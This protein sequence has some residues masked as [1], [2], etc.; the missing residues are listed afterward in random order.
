[1]FVR[2][3]MALGLVW[4]T[5]PANAETTSVAVME[6]ASKGGVTQKQ[7]DALG[8]MLANEIRDL[9][10]FRVIGKSDIRAMLQFE[11]QKTLMGCSDVAC[12]AEIGGA[13]GVK[14]VVIGNIGMFGN[15]YLLNLKLMDSEKVQVGS[16]IS[17]KVA[18]GEAALLDS[19]ARA[20]GDLFGKVM[21]PKRT[22]TTRTAPRRPAPQTKKPSAI[23]TAQVRPNPTNPAVQTTSTL[24]AQAQ[25]SGPFAYNTWG[26]VSMWTGVGVT[27]LGILSFLVSE[28]AKSDWMKTGDKDLV[29]KHEMWSSLAYTGLL[30]GAGL[31]A[32]GTTLWLLEPDEPESSVP[33]HT[34]SWSAGMIT[35]GST[36]FL[37]IGG[38]W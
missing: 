34:A 3:F 38:R 24:E 2:I 25:A 30:L 12:M 23:T 36:C 4:G 5:L 13:L 14:W 35:D 10:D 18:G 8:D 15:I 17:R 9:G 29:N 27:S 22:A 11:E 31:I 19:L 26:H 7:M 6:F 37:H 1:M 33:A 21:K 32:T 16:S 28:G 20:V